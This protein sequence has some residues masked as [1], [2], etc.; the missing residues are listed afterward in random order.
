MA[1]R[2]IGRVAFG[3]IAAAMGAGA[4]CGGDDDGGSSD[5]C[6]RGNAVLQRCGLI[7]EPVECAPEAERP[8]AECTVACLE[9]T[10]CAT[11][12]AVFCTP[13]QLP[14]E[15][16]EGLVECLD[17]CWDDG[18]FHCASGDASID[19]TYQCDGEADCF[20]GSDEVGCPMFACGDGTSVVQSYQCDGFPDCSGGEDE[21]ACEQHSCGDGT[22]VPLSFRCDFENDC[23][24]ASDESGC[25]PTLVVQ[26]N[27]TI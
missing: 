14:P 12:V 20:D 17:H 13:D 21:E 26:C 15:D 4:A 3:L 6:A 22:T 8:N 11:L 16:A 9:A 23:A 27:A 24:D 10:E 1:G 2:S 7:G 18:G 25:E 5:F 19:P